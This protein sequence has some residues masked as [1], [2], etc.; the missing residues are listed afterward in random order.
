MIDSPFY[1]GTIR[2]YT[3]AFGTVFNDIK[4]VKKTST[5]EKEMHVPI[6]YGPKSHYYAALQKNSQESSNVTS[7]DLPQMSYDFL[8]PTYAPDRKL[9]TMNRFKNPNEGDTRNTVYAPA[10]YD[11]EFELT[12]FAKG[13]ADAFRVLEQIL[14]QFQPQATRRNLAFRIGPQNIED[15]L[16][17]VHRCQR[18]S[19]TC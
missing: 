9:N 11:F 5:G 13:S 15:Q 6:R 17:K 1:H 4:I 16:P 3:A 18:A 8:Q 10:P 19:H 2:A 12:I 14:P 7:T